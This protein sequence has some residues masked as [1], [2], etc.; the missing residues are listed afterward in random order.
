MKEATAFLELA[1]WKTK[2]GESN[3]QNQGGT[4]HS[5]K[6]K[7][8]DFDFRKQ[9][10]VNCGADI[11]IEHVLSYLVVPP[12]EDCHSDDEEDNY[13]SSE[14]SDDDMDSDSDD[15]RSERGGLF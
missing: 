6:R 2:L 12:P 1:L 5:K 4:R 15:S 14:E 10:R 13:S 11:V 9:C 3:G 8:E 7:I